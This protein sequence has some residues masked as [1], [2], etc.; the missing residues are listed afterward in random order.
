MRVDASYAAPLLSPA[1]L[2]ATPSL[3]SQ[4]VDW[5][6][7][8]Q[9]WHHCASSLMRVDPSEHLFAVAESPMCPPEHREFTGEV[10]FE[11]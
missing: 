3:S 2:S 7:A 6:A 9:L 10:L 11:T 4:V 5:D 1:P 8:E